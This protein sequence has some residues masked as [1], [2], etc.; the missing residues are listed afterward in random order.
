MLAGSMSSLT[1]MT[2]LP[3]LDCKV[4]APW[5]ARQTSL[6]G[7]PSASCTKMTGRRLVSRSC[8]TTRRTPL[9]PSRSRRWLRNNGS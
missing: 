7:V 4:A 9:I 1:A 2:I 6:R 3:Q 8:I 5:S